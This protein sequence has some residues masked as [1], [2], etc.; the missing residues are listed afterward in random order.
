MKTEVQEVTFREYQG[1]DYTAIQE[2]EKEF[3]RNLYQLPTGGGKSVIIAKY[4][5]DRKDKKILVFAHKRKLL[6]QLRIRFQ[7]LGLRVGLL[8]GQNAVNLD[9]NIVIVSIRTAVKE[10]RLEKLLEED[11]THVIIDEA[12]NSRQGS[13]DKVL[14][15]LK[16]KHAGIRFF[17]VDA[18]PIRKDGKRLDKHFDNLIVSKE[19]T[20]SL[21][22]KGFFP[23]YRVIRTPIGEIDE[24]VKEQGGDYAMT[25]LSEY[26]RKP[27]FLKYVVDQYK[28]YG[29]DKQTIVFAVDKA[30]ARDLAAEFKKA[31][32]TKLAQIDSDLSDELIDK[33]FEDFETKKVQ[34]LINVEMITEG[35]DLPNIGVIIAARPTKSLSLYLQMFGRAR[36]GENKEDILTYIDCAGLTEEF[37]TVSSPKR[38]SL[39]PNINPNSHKE[40][41]KVVGKRKDG[42]YTED[43]EDFIGEVEEMDAEEYAAHLGKGLEFAEQANKSI[44]SKIADLF[45]ALWALLLHIMKNRFANFHHQSIVEV[46]QSI[47]KL[48]FVP[49][50]QREQFQQEIRD[51]EGTYRD[52]KLRNYSR[53]ELSFKQGKPVYAEVILSD[54]SRNYDP[55]FEFYMQLTLLAGQLNEIF[56]TNKKIGLQS[57]ELMEQ[58]KD[59]KDN[60]LN[61]NEFK[62]QAKK[63]EEEQH[64]KQ[65]DDF[66]KEN[67]IF[68][69]SNPRSADS[70]FKDS[71]MYRAEI[72]AI[73][74]TKN[75][76]NGHHNSIK[77]HLGRL[78]S[79]WDRDTLKNGER[80]VSKET[81]NKDYI[82][83]EKIYDILKYGEWSAENKSTET[84]ANTN[85]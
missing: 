31:G 59:L 62:E 79:Y 61:L 37:G 30:H 69:L 43:L 74:M 60:K 2:A 13:Y 36:V 7:K 26:M 39:N 33:A 67:L 42:T 77:V 20:A 54:N 70:Y 22:Q 40:T 66:V 27:K 6:S 52:W 15:A 9:A 29:N 49:S 56:L 21:I 5:L 34:I 80:Y 47:Y 71:A 14:D 72:I 76:I 63:F 44:D 45:N 83:G 55:K 32:Y 17:G 28:E 41:T 48:V 16:E 18:T 11:W 12:R 82:K 57:R 51:D 1:I 23:K 58:V 68:T 8:Q 35:V 85:K 10:A 38:W 19:D 84:V 65:I 3:L 78:P 64:Q 4:I 81:I 75:Q 73:E 50:E 46:E 24:E 25:P 53:V